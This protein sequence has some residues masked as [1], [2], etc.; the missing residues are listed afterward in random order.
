MKKFSFSILVLSFLFAAGASNIFACSCLFAE[1]KSLDEKVR[2]G[3]LNSI[4]VFS[5]EVSQIVKEPGTNQIKVKLKVKE[6]WKGKFV[7]EVTIR[8]AQDS[9]T[10]GYK[11]EVGKKYLVYAAGE[12][13]N[14]RTDICTRTS[15]LKP[16]EDVSILN[17]IKKQKIK[18]APR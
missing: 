13:N 2:E 9:A 12:E 18:S 5:G 3:Y 10:C 16:N 4:A 14:L 15:L 8:T 7:R 17:K 1:D 6:S 11:F